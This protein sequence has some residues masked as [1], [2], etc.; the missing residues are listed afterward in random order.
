MIKSGNCSLWHSLPQNIKSQ[1]HKIS[2]KYYA[3]VNGGGGIKAEIS[4]TGQDFHSILYEPLSF[5]ILK[6]LHMILK[7]L[8]YW[9]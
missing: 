9:F 7:L 8:F 1:F 6:L 2:R 3:S 5:Q 4:Y